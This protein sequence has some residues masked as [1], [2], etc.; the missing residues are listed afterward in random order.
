[1]NL[2]QWLSKNQRPWL[3]M[4]VLLL[5]ITLLGIMGV[6]I[7]YLGEFYSPTLLAVARNIFGFVPVF[8][9]LILRRN[10]KSIFSLAGKKKKT[11]YC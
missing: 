9:I 10:S 3:A 1:M 6:M 7:K 8:L 11:G 2:I 4:L 5:G